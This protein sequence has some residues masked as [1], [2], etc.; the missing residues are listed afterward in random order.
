MSPGSPRL[1]EAESI[2]EFSHARPEVQLEACCKVPLLLAGQ[3]Q[4]GRLDPAAAALTV[5]C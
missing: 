2:Q 3:R 1:P 5:P 4:L